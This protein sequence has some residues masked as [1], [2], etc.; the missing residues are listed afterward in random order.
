MHRRMRSDKAKHEQFIRRTPTRSIE[1]QNENEL[2]ACKNC[3][4]VRRMRF[5]ISTR[6]SCS[7][8][9]F[10]HGGLI[11]SIV[12]SCTFAWTAMRTRQQLNHFTFLLPNTIPLQQNPQGDKHRRPLLIPHLQYGAPLAFTLGD[13]VEGRAAGA[14]PGSCLVG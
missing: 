10:T 14:S 7:T 9:I 13:G 4:Y 8:S 2:T 6:S 11:N 3:A 12:T 1:K 5:R